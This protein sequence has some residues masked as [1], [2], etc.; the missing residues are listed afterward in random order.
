MIRAGDIY[1]YV[2]SVE[3]EEIYITKVEGETAWYYW[4]QEPELTGD[5][6]TYTI[7]EYLHEKIM[8][9]LN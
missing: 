7:E 2:D 9:K 3:V 4:M 5:M 6:P 1:Q 8:I